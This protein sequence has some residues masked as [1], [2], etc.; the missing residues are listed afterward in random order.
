VKL[1]PNRQISVWSYGLDLEGRILAS[2]ILTALNDAQEPTVDSIGH[3]VSS[4]TARIG[5]IVTGPNDELVDA[6]LTAL[7]PRG[8]LSNPGSYSKSG[9]D[10]VYGGPNIVPAEIFV[11]IKPI[12]E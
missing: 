4:T 11:G 7:K 6:L 2:Q 8:S 1:F 5:I 3:M 12:K 9:V 10:M